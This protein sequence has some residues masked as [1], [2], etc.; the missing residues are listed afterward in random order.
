MNENTS[1][2]KTLSVDE[3]IDQ[4]ISNLVIEAGV[5]QKLGDNEEIL[6]QFK[7]DL[8][9]RFENRMNATILSQIPEGKMS[10]FE[11]IL[12]SDNKEAMQDYC[13]KNIPNFSELIASE[14][15]NFRNRYID[16]N[17]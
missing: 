16:G 1:N 6:N 12:D 7:K 11:S 17:K 10:E 5:V 13:L 15:L 9:N 2:I 3:A 14:F 4:F 8:R